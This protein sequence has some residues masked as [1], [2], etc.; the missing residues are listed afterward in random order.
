MRKVHL[1]Q[2]LL[3]IIIMPMLYVYFRPWFISETPFFVVFAFSTVCHT[4]FGA[5]VTAASMGPPFVCS[6]A[7][8]S[9]PPTTTLYIP[10]TCTRYVQRT[11]Q[12]DN[13]NGVP[14]LV[15][16]GV[17][18]T[19]Y[20]LGLINARLLFLQYSIYVPPN[21]LP[22]FACSRYHTNEC[23]YMARMLDF[24]LEAIIAAAYYIRRE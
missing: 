3:Y 11:V 10:M 2:Y 22:P 20:H 16:Q 18:N 5:T 4:D 21:V 14:V 7:E 12:F 15:R 6:R 23:M 9:P 24:A 1:Q 13:N 8:N 17:G 19:T